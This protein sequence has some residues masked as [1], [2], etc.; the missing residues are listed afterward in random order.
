MQYNQELSLKTE[1]GPIASDFEMLHNERSDSLDVIDECAAIV[2]KPW[3]A[4]QKWNS[5]QHDSELKQPYQS[6][7]THGINH[8]TGL[9]AIAFFSPGGLWH[10]ASIKPQFRF[11]PNVDPVQLQDIEM[12]LRMR[13]FVHQSLLD[14]ASLEQPK[15]RGRFRRPT[16]DATFF[17]SA[18]L[19]I[20]QIF[21]TGESLQYLDEDYRLRCYAREQYVTDRDSAGNVLRHIICETIDP[22][23]L[24]DEQF[25]M[26]K[27]DRAEVEKKRGRQRQVNIYTNV[28]YQPRSGRWNIEQECN[29]H[30]FNE[31]SDPV[32]PY[33]CAGL[34]RGAYDNYHHGIIEMY[35]ADV[36]SINELT[37]RVLDAAG[38]MSK[39]LWVLDHNSETQEEEIGR[40]SGAVIRGRVEGK[41]AVEI[42][43]LRTDKA[44]DLS[45]ANEVR[46]DMEGRVAKALLAT[47]NS[48]RDSERTTAFEI[49][50]ALLDELQGV[51]GGIMARMQPGLQNSLIRRV[52]WQAKRDRFIAPIKHEGKLI[53]YS[54]LTGPAA[55]SRAGEYQK[56]KGFITDMSMLAQ[57]FPRVMLRLD[58]GAMVKRMAVLT[59][60]YTSDFVR[61]DEAVAQEEQKAL[62]MQA[63][64]QAIQ[65]A[66]TIAEGAAA[67]GAQAASAQ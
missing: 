24:T 67:A 44:V 62:A 45:F 65:S 61:S 6:S 20:D 16:W 7:I 54:F 39:I 12:Q 32:S 29:G 27:L 19:A 15:T 35:K 11:N 14:S 33:I 48:V 63:A 25:A 60:F 22:L 58:E 1:R 23:A 36:S 56:V 49:Q 38:L 9:T 57:A 50:R 18:I 31:F 64:Q 42:A 26:T 37:K 43:C 55:L 4:S 66:G 28:E 10:R 13:E 52:D 5:Q 41:E 46:R 8:L 30:T 3:H 34:E 21:V 51:H 47:S 59:D 40:P 17:A 53:E 2:G